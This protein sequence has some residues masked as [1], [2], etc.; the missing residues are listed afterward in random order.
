MSARPWLSFLTSSPGRGRQLVLLIS[1]RRNRVKVVESRYPWEQRY[2][3]GLVW[4]QEIAAKP[5]TSALDDAVADH[6]D[7]PCFRYFGAR[8][9]Y[10]DVGAMVNK[11]A[12][13]MQDL[14]I[15][16]GVNIGLL[17]P[18]SPY[19]VLC[20]Y[21]ILKAGGTVVNYN[22]LSAVDE[23]V[24]QALDSD[25]RFLVTLDVEA[26]SAKVE[27]V[28]Q[29]TPVVKLILCHPTDIS[30]IPHRWVFHLMRRRRTATR[31]VKKDGCCHLTSLLTGNRHLR[32]VEVRPLE[33]VAVLQYTGGL[34]GVLKGAMLTHANLYVNAWQA[35]SWL[36]D[37][38]PGAEKIIVA[39]PLCHGFGMT[40]AMNAG[41]LMAAEL[42]LIPQFKS[43]TVLRAIEKRRAT[44]FPGVP[45]M[46]AMIGGFDQV[47]RYDLSS[48][49]ICLSGGT[50]L[51]ERVKRR[52][53]QRT[54]CRVIE[55]YGLTEATAVVT[56]NTA[57]EATEESCV[58]L[59][60]P[61]TVVEVV[62]LSHRKRVLS[63]GDKGKGEGE[64]C[65]SGP[66]V[67]KGYWRR[68]EET[69]AALADGRLH[70][71]D[72]GYVD[73]SGR[74][75]LTGRIKPLILVGGFNVY[76][77]IVE[78]AI[79]AHPAVADAVA[80]G[81]PDEHLGEKVKAC[82][83]LRTGQTVTA[84]E[85]RNFLKQRLAPFEMPKQIEFVKTLPHPAAKNST[86]RRFLANLLRL[87]WK[88][89]G[90]ENREAA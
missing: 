53:E 35:S 13:G 81:I 46:F 32:P 3:P 68:P 40:I 38:R 82:V 63:P 54:G 31:P 16:P 51:P 12:A 67:M 80:E 85:L 77:R 4:R 61:G 78:E 34:N 62:S 21:A 50:S 52:F 59:P 14:G 8:F 30:P 79:R 44:I 5:L 74:L 39:L 24:R 7:A 45:T 28:L 18:N 9:T 66:Q 65:V 58:G 26:L 42:I 43:T 2:P 70:T 22:P 41:V 29:R 6:P 60:L 48:L 20:Y 76:P 90:R 15:G 88:R 36:P 86:H 23:I 72:A 1:R 69:A 57:D 75:H 47:A 56:C 10:R 19:F 33:D 84:F 71:G 55:G 73:D 64:V 37:L 27:A 49:K 25:T 17:L 11:V 83:R 87:R 89:R